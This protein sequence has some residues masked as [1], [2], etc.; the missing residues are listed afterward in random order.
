MKYRYSKYTGDPLDDLDL[1]DL[2]E[3][4]SDLLLSSGF[5]SPF[6]SMSRNSAAEGVSP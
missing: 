3:K 2:I 5:H 6:N 4:L 1:D